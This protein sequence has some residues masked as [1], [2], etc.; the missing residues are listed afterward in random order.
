MLGALVECDLAGL[1]SSAQRNRLAQLLKR[2]RHRTDWEIAY[3]KSELSRAIQNGV[4]PRRASREYGLAVTKLLG[5]ALEISA[6]ASLMVPTVDGREFSV[7]FGQWSVDL[8]MQV[9]DLFSQKAGVSTGEVYQPLELLTADAL[10]P[11]SP[12]WERAFGDLCH[13]FRGLRLLKNPQRF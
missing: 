8:R 6:R 9:D 12:V 5:H 10:T 1:L 13:L 4:S 2:Y 7:S 3:R 11:Q